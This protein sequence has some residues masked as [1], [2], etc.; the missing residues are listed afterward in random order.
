[1]QK[2]MLKIKKKYGKNA[3]LKGMNFEEGAY[4]DRAQR[5]GRRA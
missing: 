2:A 4:D 5:S 3:I 1:M